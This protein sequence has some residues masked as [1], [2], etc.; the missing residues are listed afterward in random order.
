MALTK[1]GNYLRITEIRL[2]QGLV[3]AVVFESKAI[4]DKG[5][6]EFQQAIQITMPMKEALDVEAE[7]NSD[8]TKSTID[9]VKTDAYRALK[10]SSHK[11]WSNA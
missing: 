4:A 5:L 3:T 2:I 6:G 7:T 10:A 1:N 11:D 9:N 8:S